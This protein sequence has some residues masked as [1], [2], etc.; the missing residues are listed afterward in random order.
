VTGTEPTPGLPCA[1]R[2]V[3]TEPMESSPFAILHSSPSS[4]LARAALPDDALLAFGVSAL[5][6]HAHAAGSHP[7][8]GSARATRMQNASLRLVL[9]Q[10]RNLVEATGLCDSR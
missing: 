4:S 5:R 3:R 6:P 7:R 1:F 10:P 2:G 8:A 9:P